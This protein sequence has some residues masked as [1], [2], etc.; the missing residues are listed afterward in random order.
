MT[1]DDK[2]LD[3]LQ[4]S[5]QF[6]HTIKPTKGQKRKKK[7][8]CEILYSFP[9]DNHYFRLIDDRENC[10]N[11]SLKVTFPNK[12]NMMF[13]GIDNILQYLNKVNVPLT[14]ILT[15]EKKIMEITL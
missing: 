15:I 12:K 11:V 7:T 13:T 3:F 1:T 9:F 5:K 4:F 10:N 6:F 8:K 14:Q 2:Y